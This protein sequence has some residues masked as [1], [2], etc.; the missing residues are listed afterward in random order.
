MELEV[1]TAL[2]IE[3]VTLWDMTPCRLL[4][5]SLAL[6]YPEHFL[7]VKS[8]LHSKTNLEYV[9]SLTVRTPVF[10]EE[11]ELVLSLLM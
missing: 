11:K 1:L 10:S 9:L 4:T 6:V 5:A 3:V 2:N 8:T 7:S